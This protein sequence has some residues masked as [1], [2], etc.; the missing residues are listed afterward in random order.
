MSVSSRFVI[1]ENFSGIISAWRDP[2]GMELEFDALVE[3]YYQPLYRF[4]YSLSKREA[5]AADLT[6]QTFYK[7]ATKGNQLKD[8]SKVK[9]WLFT[10]LHR[11]FL[12]SRR[13]YQRFPHHEVG[14]VE[15][16]LPAVEPGMAREMDGGSVMEAL[17][18]VDEMY[19]GPLTLFYLQD[20]SYKEISTALELPI[21]TVMSRLSRGKEQLRMLL[22]AKAG[23]QRRKVISLEQDLEQNKDERHG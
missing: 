19:R 21:G 17:T 12:G 10:T 5:D 20:L 8:K 14:D 15:H 2:T 3:M 6:Q 11:E 16:E 7:W 18:E 1:N 22:A 4:A 23:R 13:R 9:T